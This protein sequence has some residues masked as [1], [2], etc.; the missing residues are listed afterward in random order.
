MREV[1]IIEYMAP[2]IAR[3]NINDEK[4]NLH[5]DVDTAAKAVCLACVNSRGVYET[6]MLLHT[7]SSK[8][9]LTRPTIEV[10]HLFSGV[11]K[12]G[13]LIT[14]P[15]TDSE[16]IETRTERKIPWPKITMRIMQK[17]LICDDFLIRSSVIQKPFYKKGLP[18]S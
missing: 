8:R 10:F 16:E 1:R 9:L 13:S 17:W 2:F 15:K 6:I 7:S 14:S 3:R 12:F 11:H 5:R 4:T 18:L